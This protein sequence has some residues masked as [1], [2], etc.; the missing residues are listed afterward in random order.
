MNA[1]KT[2]LSIL[3]LSGLLLAPFVGASCGGDDE[4]ED[5]EP[6]GGLGG[7]DPGDG[8]L[9]SG[10]STG[11]GT[12]S[13]AGNPTGGMGGG[14][15]MPPM[16]DDSLKRCP[17]AFSYKGS[18]VQSVEIRGDFA[19]GAWDTGVAMKQ[20]GDEWSAIVDIPYNKQIVYKFL[21][22]GTD[23]ITDP[24][25]L[26]TVDDGFGGKNS[27]LYPEQCDVFTCADPVLPPMGNF[28]WRDGVLYFV[29]VDRFVD[30]DPSNNGSPSPGV[31]PPADYHGGDWKGV[32]DKIN[33][34][35]F[36]QLGVN[37]LWLTVPANNPAQPGQGSGNDPHKYS[38][39]HGYWP[40]DLDKPEEH[41][42]SMADLKA[43]VDAAHAK[44]IKVIIDYAMNHVHASAPVYQQHPDW[45]WANDNGSGGDCLCGAGCSWEGAQGEKCWFTSYLPDFNF[46]NPD[47]RKY[48][49]DNAMWWIQET[50][51]DGFR[52]DA[53]KHIDIQWLKDLRA[54]VSTEIEPVTKEYF[55]TV[56]ETFTGDKGLIAKYV[57]PQTMLGG[58][59]DFPLRMQL[60]YSVLMRKGTM[61]E[62]ELFLK[63]NDVYGGGIMS[64]FIG[65]HDIPRPIHLAQDVPLWDNQWTDGKD[66]SWN[67]T[68]GLPA[69]KSAFERL[70][71]A[72][73]LLYTTKGIPLIYYGDEVGMPGA[74]DPDNRRPMQWSNYSAGQTFL[75]GHLEK[76]GQIRKEHPALR[77]GSWQALWATADTM[78]YQM[79]GEGET[80][81]VAINRGDGQGSVSGLP[82]GA[83]KDLVSGA[84]VNGPTVN[85]PA[86][87]SMILV[88]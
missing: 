40:Q 60:A 81:Y 71:N 5:Y 54:R 75:R 16:C 37:V 85:L 84:T 19:P 42:G 33:A 69:E 66:K 70:A 67:N 73:T 50:G 56:G 48:S 78:A 83:L 27:V 34:D 1:P 72:F 80:V 62:L 14:G 35:Y 10:S 9:T 77:R 36:T 79:S 63:S 15:P 7:Y 61:Q 21:L 20:Q 43:L 30:G 17:H 3:A 4:L 46:Q 57:N 51:V 53:V 88:P 74:G 47:A 22:N 6:P 58:Q 12:G 44:G 49:I 45:F 82:S 55:Y 86:R 32:I 28:D 41:F 52:L 64:T 38:G 8:G 18:D 26:S 2:A 76:L 68:P 25:N 65:N 31:E 23:W 13:G 59:F 39:Y 87:T 11:T 24:N 29:F